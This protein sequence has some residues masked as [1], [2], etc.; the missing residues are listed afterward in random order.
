MHLDI[1]PTMIDTTLGP[2]MVRR[3][4]SG[5]PALLW[6]SLFVD[7]STF[8]NVVDSLGQERELILLDGPGHGGSP[9]PRRPYSLVE[10]A[11]AANQILD[12]LGIPGPVDWVG[13]AWGGHVGIVFADT[14][15]ARCRTLTTIGSP[16]YPLSRSERLQIVPMVYAY[17]ILGP[18]PFT[19]GIANALGGKGVSKSAPQAAAAVAEAFRRGSRRDK[20]WAMQSV[21]LRRPD[22]R[23]V[24]ARL[25]V[26]T[27]VLVGRNDPMNDA[28]EAERAARSVR[29]GR[30]SVVTGAGHVA[31]L[32]IEPG[33]VTR[34]IL[35]FWSESRNQRAAA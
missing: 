23:P 17:R 14:F 26:P 4:G 11:V 13:N 19:G 25:Q 3:R 34:H 2:L 8:A 35:A 27:L 22:L 5:Q 30:F 12:A 24:L 6:H 1:S 32:L 18:A 9:G 29:D 33:E 20:Y 31:P 10:C 21:M 28:A 7:S 16:P 15:P